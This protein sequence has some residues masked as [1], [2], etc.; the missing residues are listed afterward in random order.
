[1]DFVTPSTHRNRWF[2]HEPKIYG[3]RATNLRASFAI[4]FCRINCVRMIQVGNETSFLP[5]SLPSLLI[6]L[7]Y[8]CSPFG[9]DGF[10]WQIDL[11][12]V[13]GWRWFVCEKNWARISGYSHLSL[14]AERFST[15]FCLK[16]MK[17]KANFHVHLLKDHS[18]ITHTPDLDQTITNICIINFPST[19]GPNWL[20]RSKLVIQLQLFPQ[21]SSH[22]PRI[23]A[24]IRSPTR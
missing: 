24:Q 16:I 15:S 22:F 23:T 5:C 12:S 6:E 3:A 10:A 13:G 18:V 17:I 19:P 21:S 7:I 20:I 8:F 14:W 2:Q 11:W 1:M 4:N 9:R